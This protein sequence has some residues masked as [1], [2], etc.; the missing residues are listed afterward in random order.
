VANE[1]QNN[2]K[3]Q[4]G[5]RPPVKMLHPAILQVASSR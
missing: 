5:R 1:R 4:D 2:D 3:G